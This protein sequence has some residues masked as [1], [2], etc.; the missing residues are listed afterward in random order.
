MDANELPLR[1]FNDV[2]A[3]VVISAIDGFFGVVGVVGPSAVA[4]AAAI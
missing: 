3:M 1:S 2:N 4:L